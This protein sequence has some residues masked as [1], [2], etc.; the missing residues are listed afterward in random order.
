MLLLWSSP[1][2][3]ARTVVVSTCCGRS[4]RGDGRPTEVIGVMH[5][6]G[7]RFLKHVGR[8]IIAHD[9][10]QGAACTNH[11][12]VTIEAKAVRCIGGA[13]GRGWG[14]TASCIIREPFICTVRIRLAAR[15]DFGGVHGQGILYRKFRAVKMIYNDNRTVLFRS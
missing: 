8:F 6:A 10:G 15:K 1:Y 4:R 13:G 12:D 3:V 2:A 7:T 11:V 5:A 14:G 9:L